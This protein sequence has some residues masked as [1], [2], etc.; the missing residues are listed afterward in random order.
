MRR[1]RWQRQVFEF[2]T[3]CN[4]S[5]ALTLREPQAGVK[6]TE[7]TSKAAKA[8]KAANQQPRRMRDFAAKAAHLP[9]WKIYIKTKENYTVQCLD[10]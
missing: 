1:R 6:A 3:L 7:T 8:A 4:T 2:G 5:N 9:Q 10:Y